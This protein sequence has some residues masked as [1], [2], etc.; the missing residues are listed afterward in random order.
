MTLRVKDIAQAKEFYT[1]SLRPL[2]YAIAKE[3]MEWKVVGMGTGENVDFWIIEKPDAVGG[4]HFAFQAEDRETV[5]AFHK[6]ALAAGGKDNGG[7]GIRKEYSPSYY[8]A[9]VFDADGNNVEVVC[10]KPE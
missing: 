4:E 1:K 9:F 5:D 8:G 10:H 3:F 7:P 6:A 2:G